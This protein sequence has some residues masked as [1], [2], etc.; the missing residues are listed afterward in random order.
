MSHWRLW[1]VAPICDRQ[2][3]HQLARSSLA[4]RRKLGRCLNGDFATLRHHVARIEDKI[5]ERALH[6]R[7]VDKSQRKIV[8][9][10]NFEA[11]A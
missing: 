1:K 8:G 3:D 5:E 2:A 6:E 10:I 7:L 4:G 9:D 11:D